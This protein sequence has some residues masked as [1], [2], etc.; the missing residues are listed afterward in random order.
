M[1]I[2]ILNNQIEK[3]P[4]TPSDLFTEFSDTSFPAD[5]TSADISSFG[6]YNVVPADRP[7]VDYTQVVEE[8]MPVLN[9]GRWTQVWNIRTA[10]P[11]EQSAAVAKIV[12]ERVDAVQSHLDQVAQTRNYS[13]ILSAC[14]YAS[15]THPKYSAEGKACLEWRE[16]VWDTCYQILNEVQAGTRPVPT[17]EEVIAELPQLIWPVL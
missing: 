15:G 5:L 7:I 14:S 12:Q 11:E 9:N 4:Y 1:F 3:Y 17:N 8:V 2:K 13:S 6:V 16:A 10:T